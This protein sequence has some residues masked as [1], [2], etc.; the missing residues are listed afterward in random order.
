M[1]AQAMEEA[2]W[3]MNSK[4]IGAE[5]AQSIGAYVITPCAQDARYGAKGVIICPD[6]FQSCFGSI[7]RFLP[8]TQFLLIPPFLKNCFG[9]LIV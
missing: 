8:T 7:L 5:P 1:L 9:S 2:M 4:D 6:G 3:T